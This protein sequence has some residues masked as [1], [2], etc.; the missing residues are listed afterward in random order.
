MESKRQEDGYN[1]PYNIVE[2]TVKDYMNLPFLI[3]KSLSG[4]KHQIEY[5]VQDVRID[6]Y[7]LGLW[8]GDGTSAQPEFTN[9][10]KQILDH[11]KQYADTNNLKIKLKEI[12]NDC[13]RYRF[14]AY[15]N[16]RNTFLDS[17]KY[18]NLINNKHIPDVYLYNSRKIR[19]QVLAGIIDTDGYM[20]H[21]MYEIAQKSDKIA[22]GIVILEKSLGLRVTRTKKEKKCYKP[23]GETVSGM[24]NFMLISGNKISDLPLLI[25]YKKAN[26]KFKETN[27]FTK[28][29][30]KNYGVGKFIGFQIEGDGKFLAPDFTVWHNSTISTD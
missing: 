19:L 3:K 10:D 22:D 5:D 15:P 11:I 12:K 29:S 25:D 1:K 7:M 21:N 6:A 14:Y 8:L 2:I 9:K 24:Y 28:I 13:Y 18:Y 4:F 30:I 16:K 17:L 26:P 20:Y 23:N 27:L